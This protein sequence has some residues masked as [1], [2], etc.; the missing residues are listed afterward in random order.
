MRFLNLMITIIIIFG[1]STLFANDVQKIYEELENLSLLN[2][3][4]AEVNNFSFSRDV[5]NFH[6][7]NGKLYLLSPVNGK[8][9]AAIFKGEGTVS[10]TPPTNISRERLYSKFQVESYNNSFD[11]LFLVFTDSTLSEF[12]QKLDFSNEW[13]NPKFQV[14]IKNC[15]KYLYDH[16]DNDYNSALLQTILN[17]E[18]DGYFYAHLTKGILNKNAVFFEFNPNR[19]EE[20]SLAVR[21]KKG[22]HLDH[23]RKIICMFHCQEDYLSGVDLSFEKKDEI[24]VDKYTIDA[25]ITNRMK[26]SATCTLEF[27]GLKNSGKWIELALFDKLRINSIITDNGDTLSFFKEDESSVLWVELSEKLTKSESYTINI[28][29]DGDLIYQGGKI[30]KIRSFNF[31]YPQYST[32][33]LKH[34]DITFHYPSNYDLISVGKKVSEEKLKKVKTAR[35]VTKYPVNFAPFNMGKFKNEEFNN[36]SIPTL[37]LHLNKNLNDAKADV[38]NSIAFYQAVYGKCKFDT[39]TVTEIPQFLSGQA[40]PGLINF[41]SDDF[42]TDAVYK[43][44]FDI[45]IN[46]TDFVQLRSHEVAHQWWGC[47][48]GSR[49]YHD[50]WLFEGLAEFSSIWFIQTSLNDTKK[51]FEFLTKW[52]NKIIKEHKLTKNKD[53]SECPLW[54]GSRAPNYINYYKGGWVFHMLRNLMIDLKT[55]DESRFKTMMQ[56][57]Y[58]TYKNSTATTEDFKKIVEKHMRTDMTWFF[59]QWV[60]G[61][62]IPKYK[63]DYD[64]V[65]KD[66]GKYYAECNIEQKNVSENFKSYIPI[67]IDF[68]NNQKARIRTLVEGS[69]KVFELPLPQ[70]PKKILFNILDSILCED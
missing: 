7:D 14:N 62:E 40:Y 55:Y 49:S 23:Y 41:Y 44:Y 57:F 11:L 43:V 15:M 32:Y 9:I 21:Y 58:N 13:I 25:T 67:E 53:E 8:S 56:D 63:F 60:Y 20:V 10:I 12:Y 16:K 4:V 38:A 28:N 1:I 64:I 47:G 50:K 68:G 66:D 65:K 5:A 61:N 69:G 22:T 45:D 3:K 54:L 51:Y 18:Q 24:Y 31:W 46:K 59:D 29:Y 2:D 34:F 36:P 42:I 48:I 30:V 52:R 17:N 6:L 33:N 37:S 26:F 27:H 39:L 35:W 70:K 19:T